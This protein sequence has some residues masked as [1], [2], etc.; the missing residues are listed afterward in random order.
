MGHTGVK[1]AVNNLICHK[2]G[3]LSFLLTNYCQLWKKAMF[4]FVVALGESIS[5][6]H[7]QPFCFFLLELT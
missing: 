4:L 5:V 6:P 7:R 3:V 1:W 2:L